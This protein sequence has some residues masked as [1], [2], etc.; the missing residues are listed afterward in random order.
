MTNE[1]LILVKYLRDLANQ[2]E[3]QGVHHVILKAKSP[4]QEIPISILAA[5]PYRVLEP[6]GEVKV[7]LSFWW[8]EENK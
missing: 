3:K 6:T 7:N 5:R 1:N 8:N 2:I 4:T